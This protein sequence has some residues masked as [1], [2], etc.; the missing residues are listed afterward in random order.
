MSAPRLSRPLVLEAPVRQPDGAGGWTEDWTPLG[1]VWAEMVPRTGGLR[2]A[3]AAV[4][5]R[6]PWKITLRAAPVGSPRRPRPGQRLTD[7]ARVFA[8]HAVAEADPMG[9]YLVCDAEEEVA[10]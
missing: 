6:V 9:L 8:I 4:T 2:S 7:G 1:T 5:G 10:A 3:G